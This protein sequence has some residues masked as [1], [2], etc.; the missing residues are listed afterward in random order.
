[1]R[2]ALGSIAVVGL[3]PG[4]PALRTCA[5]QRALDAAD[6]IIVRTR[7]HPGLEDLIDD[8]RVRDC[9]DLYQTARSFDS[10]YEAIADRVIDRAVNNSNVVFAVPGHPRFGEKAVRLIETRAL[11]A[12]IP[13]VI[14]DAVSCVD[15][16]VNQLSADPVADGLQV[17]DAADLAA[18]LEA[19]PFAAGLL[20]VS[21]L[22]P[23]LVSQVYN[24]ELATAVKLALPRVYPGEIA[25][26]VI[27]AASVPDLERTL[28][29]PLS[30]LD[31]QQV[32]HLT[33][34]WVPALAPLEALRTPESLLRIVARLRRPDGCPWDRDQSHGTLRDALL[35]EVFETVDAID[36]ENPH[37]LSEELGDVL[38][39][40]AMHAQIA[41]EAGEFTFEDICEE[42]AR[43]LIRRHPHVFST[44]VAES[45]DAVVATWNS[46]KAAERAMK[47]DAA[48]RSS[49]VDRLPRSMPAVRKAVELLGSRQVLRA[50]EN[51][52]AGDE[53]LRC[54]RALID[55]GIDPERALESSLRNLDLSSAVDR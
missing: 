30:A 7:V 34:V 19:E 3:G 27:R 52:G 41:E 47:G 32:D 39:L 36:S 33:S 25:V 28:T 14:Q 44:V 49:P 10:L 55:R 40:V 13:I 37:A 26:T 2:D 11:A 48:E 42:I 21:P 54:I 23:L 38:L 16:V 12:G 1:M 46:V 51:S 9:D 45:P 20:D 43:K 22:R 31:R 53:L 17:L 29:V 4:D 35:E 18:A 15:A 6:S 5:A 24:G 50:P 8:P